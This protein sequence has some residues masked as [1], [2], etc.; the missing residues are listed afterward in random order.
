MKD[1]IRKI[2]CFL[3]LDLTK[4][5]E[6]DR[7]TKLILKK[8]LKED[9]NC[10]DI[11]CHKGEILELMLTYAPKGNH[12]AF[13]PLPHLFQNLKSLFDKKV[14]IHPFALANE[15][16]SSTFQFVKNA[17]AYSGIKKR[18]YAVENPDIEEIDVELKKL[19]EVVG[20]DIKIDLIKIDV[21][22]AEFN[23]LKGAKNLLKQHKPLVVFECG[24]GASEFYDTNPGDVY[25]YMVDTIGLNLFTLKAFIK[26]LPSMSKEEF[27]ATYNDKKEYYFVASC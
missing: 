20:S 9:S 2:L 21:E 7:L 12:I 11:G 15:N 10:I 6:Y 16:G 3:H 14:T 23:V 8:V 5:L 19:D 22:G 1:L 25:D 26:N 27:L 24:L 13:E 18:E 17:P 4:N